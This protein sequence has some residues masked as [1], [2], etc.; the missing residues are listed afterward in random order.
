M[1]KAIYI[2]PWGT[3]IFAWL[4]AYAG[5]WYT[6]LAFAILGIFQWVLLLGLMAAKYKI[7]SDADL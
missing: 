7:K 5:Q 4:C 3:W 6:A 2:L 1:N